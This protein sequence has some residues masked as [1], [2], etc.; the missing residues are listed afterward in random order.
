MNTRY[1]SLSILGK[2]LT[3]IE[4]IQSL[5]KKGDIESMYKM[6]VLHIDTTFNN[7]QPLVS[8]YWFQ[9][10]AK[11]GHLLSMLELSYLYLDSKN[12]D[13]QSVGITWLERAAAQG[14]VQARNLLLFYQAKNLK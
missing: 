11:N 6:G 1:F 2:N 13:L 8:K 9:Q 3:T 5:A 7:I 14:L 4:N 10:A 12:S